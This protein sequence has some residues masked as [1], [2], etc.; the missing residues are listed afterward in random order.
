[1]TEAIRS[2]DGAAPRD[3]VLNSIEATE[4]RGLFDPHLLE[5]AY[6][7][8][9]NHRYW[10]LG[11]IAGCLLFGLL[12][13]FLMTPLY[14]STSRIEILPDSPV[15]TS[16]EG[17]REKMLSNEVAF[18]NTQYS[19]LES[20]SLAERVVRAGNLL[21]DKAFT[22]AYELESEADGERPTSQSRQ[23]ATDRAVAILLDNVSINPVRTSSLVDISFSTP[24]NAL[25][26]KLADL[27]VKQ[28]MQANTDRRFAATSDARRFLERRIGELR[29]NVE[30]S[31]RS[32]INYATTNDIVTISSQTDATGK[33]RIDKTLTSSQIE[34]INKALSDAR[35]ARIAA[36]SDL[37]NTASGPGSTN[38]VAINALR[39][40]RAEVAADLANLRTTFEDDYPQ[41]QALKAQLA[42]L[43]RSLS[44]ESTRSRQGNR[45]AY[46]S[47]AKRERQLQAELDRLVGEYGAQQR[48]SIEYAILQREVDTNRQLYD[49]L[50]QRYKEIGAAGVGTNNVSVVEQPRPARIPS[51][52]R[53][54]LNMALALLAGIGL[55]ALLVF[56]LEQLDRSIRDPA[57][58]ARRFG[59]PLLGAIPLVDEDNFLVTLT[60]KKSVLYEAYLSLQ[61]NLSFLTDHGAPRSLMITSTRPG[62]GK[63]SSSISLATVLTGIGKSVL[64][65]DGDIRSPSVHERLGMPNKRG[66]SN[67]LAGDDDLS[68]VISTVPEF[69]FHILSAGP[70]A[71]NAAEL[72]SSDRFDRL[73]QGQLQHFDHVIID[74]PPVLGLA[75]A[76]LLARKVEGVIFTVQANG[77]TIRAIRI[78]L[79]R[80]RMSGARLFG[81]IVTKIGRKNELY[82]YGYGDGYGYGYGASSDKE[83]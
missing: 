53:L 35:A 12:A 40:K 66:L 26:A 25:S 36:E 59:M 23:A 22:A 44:T 21:S 45:E 72:F 57:D 16:V 5:S 20:R 82:G 2:A 75:D 3:A 69:G 63:S 76:P 77:T 65:I 50:L 18:Y 49:G 1:M 8:L 71:P 51:S 52:P 24:S 7:A 4:E 34:E 61:T 6:I 13:T 9:M 31:E 55:S 43:D 81:A 68:D 79:T 38:V 33:T 60:D 11:T 32:L 74:A 41:I 54:I 28:F 58:V 42:E 67:F 10:V 62:E 37:A 39:Q 19:L 80:M 17:A 56:L 27:W 30:E 15:E 73:I 83:A 78:A 48:R 46:D 47:A 14:T 64:L 70:M 29:R